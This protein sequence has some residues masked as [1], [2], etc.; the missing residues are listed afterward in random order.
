MTYQERKAE[1]L[2]RMSNNEEF[3]LDTNVIVKAADNEDFQFIK[4]VILYPKCTLTKT[5]LNELR[6]LVFSGMFKEKKLLWV[7]NFINAFVG[8][9]IT[10]PLQE[11]D[12]MEK[13]LDTLVPLIPRSVAYHVLSQFMDQLMQKCDQF[14]QFKTS[15]TEEDYKTFAEE[16]AKEVETLRIKCENRYIDLSENFVYF[17]QAVEA[18]YM[19]EVLK[20]VDMKLAEIWKIVVNSKGDFDYVKREINKLKTKTYDNDVRIVA[21]S[22]ISGIETISDDSDVM[23]LFTIYYLRHATQTTNP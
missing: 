14:K 18:A 11:R 19:Q 3:T 20:F 16:Y 10:V 13:E 4:K 21:E 1:L 2:G 12:K 17:P 9:V 15:L 5:G 6:G 7:N 8:R 23:W 22:I